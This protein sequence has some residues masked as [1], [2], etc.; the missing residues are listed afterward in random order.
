[1]SGGEGFFARMAQR[2]TGRE[3]LVRLRAPQPFEAT[4]P[5]PPADVPADVAASWP[6]STAAAPTPARGIPERPAAP[7]LP[8]TGPGAAPARAAHRV[9]EQPRADRTPPVTLPEAAPPVPNR[10]AAVR[11]EPVGPA[12]REPDTA[13]PHT[14]APPVAPPPDASPAPEPTRPATVVPPAAPAPAP[15]TRRP[16]PAPVRAAGP[17]LAR[18][19]RERLGPA[20]TARRAV[21]PGE[22][23]VFVDRP[24]GAPPRPGTA[25][26]RTGPVRP[27]P[28]PPPGTAQDAPPSGDVH[29]HI[30]RVVVTRAPAPPPPAPPPPA[31]S[32]VDHAAYLARRRE[33]R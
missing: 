27:A 11:T 5:D 33:G 2:A 32:T 14:A 20:L 13:V 21:E 23:L 7:P 24:T 26:V 25:E 17:D 12:G 18:L 29:L 6:E 16:A 22:R 30:D 28:T 9:A 15:A 31:R 19:L 1:M 10:A 8:P 4:V 3:P